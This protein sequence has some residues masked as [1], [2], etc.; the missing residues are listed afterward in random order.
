MH[1]LISQSVRELV[2]W[3]EY[4]CSS[5]KNE[6]PGRVH[7]LC[8]ELLEKTNQCLERMY[9]RYVL[10]PKLAET[11]YQ[12]HLSKTVVAAIFHLIISKKRGQINHLQ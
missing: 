10:E 6:A 2:Q 5:D 11:V 1:F 12:E 8:F 9:Y 7:Q 3:V 4:I